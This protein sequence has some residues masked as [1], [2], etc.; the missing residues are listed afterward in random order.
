MPACSDH[1]VALQIDHEGL[2]NKYHDLNDIYGEKVRAHARTQKLYDTL[3]KQMLQLDVQDAAADAVSNTLDG[4]ANRFGNPMLGAQNLQRNVP[5][6][7]NGATRRVS[8]GGSS[9]SGGRREMPQGYE[10]REQPTNRAWQEHCEAFI[11]RSC[12]GCPFS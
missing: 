2:R 6:H 11:L 12:C 1:L 8:P 5:L 3:K 9:G 4:P 7:Q 10:S